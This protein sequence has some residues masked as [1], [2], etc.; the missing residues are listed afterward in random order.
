MMDL[1]LPLVFQIVIRNPGSKES[2]VDTFV[3]P[4]PEA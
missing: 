1:R 4:L 2:S 3:R